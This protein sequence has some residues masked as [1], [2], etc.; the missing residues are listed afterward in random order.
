MVRWWN[1]KEKK[2]WTYLAILKT[3]P[4]TF[5]YWVQELKT[6]LDFQMI[7]D[8]PLAEYLISKEFLECIDYISNY[9]LNSE[10]AQ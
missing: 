6:N 7:F 4:G 5:W 2:F 8:I 10:Q 1:T 3:I 9:L